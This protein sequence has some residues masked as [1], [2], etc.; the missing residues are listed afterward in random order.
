MY[1]KYIY[2]AGVAFIFAGCAGYLTNTTATELST[3]VTRT[4]DTKLTIEQIG[5]EGGNNV[6]A[7]MSRLSS[8]I[9][10]SPQV[11]IKT[12]PEGFR[13]TLNS[14]LLFDTDSHTIKESP[15]YSKIFNTLKQSAY[16]GY[17]ME[18]HTDALGTRYYNQS[19]SERRAASL[20]E[21]LTKMEFPMDHITIKAYGE[22]QPVADNSFEGGQQLNRRIE[23]AVFATD[24]LKE[25]A[26][27]GPVQ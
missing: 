9:V 26:K 17:L 27:K 18:V 12:Y 19:L 8:Q 7:Y 15:E 14:Q 6:N 23:V 22:D 10:S 5:G 11:K 3:P 21:M 13:I 4:V 24:V 16:T 25:K 1:P 20:K 2:L